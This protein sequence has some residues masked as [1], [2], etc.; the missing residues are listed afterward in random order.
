MR[1]DRG[2]EGRRLKVVAHYGDDAWVVLPAIERA[3][4]YTYIPEGEYSAHMDVTR[5]RVE[6]P[7]YRVIRVRDVPV[8]TQAGD[9]V[10]NQRH[11]LHPANW[12][13]QLEGCVAP[14]L[15]W[16]GTEGVASST[17]AMNAI[18]AVLGGF[19]DGRKLAVRVT[20]MAG[21]EHV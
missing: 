16:M 11:L 18:F 7:I 9:V 5:L 12:P 17:D 2:V 8:V 19:A 21:A 13:R 14:G 10:M 3:G 20:S 6:G 4:D 1:D 15:S